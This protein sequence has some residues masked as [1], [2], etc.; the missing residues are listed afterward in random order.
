[1]RKLKDD[2][3]WASKVN[4]DL[5]ADTQVPNNCGGTFAMC[6]GQNLGRFSQDSRLLGHI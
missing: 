4:E 2:N 5:T 3:I 6:I 1:M